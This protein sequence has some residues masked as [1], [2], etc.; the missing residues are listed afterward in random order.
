M[1]GDKVGERLKELFEQICGERE[2]II[3]ELE[4]LPDHA[5]TFISAPPKWV[6]SDIAKILKGASA[7]WLMMEYPHLK[8]NGHL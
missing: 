6:P 8:K 5:H 2:W 1:L 4:I 3:H 7:R